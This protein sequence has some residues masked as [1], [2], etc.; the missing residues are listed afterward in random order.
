MCIRDRVEDLGGPA[1]FGFVS[2]YHRGAQVPEGETEFQF[3]QADFSFH[4]DT[5]EWLVVNKEGT[6]AQYKG[7]GVC[8]VVGVDRPCSFMLW[9]TDGGGT[10]PG[11]GDKFR[12]AIWDGAEAPL[13]DNGTDTPIEEGTIIIHTSGK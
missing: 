7:Y 6:N 4:S 2:K 3:H 9:G 1:T 12:I 8:T 5:Y 13:Y 10:I 11:V